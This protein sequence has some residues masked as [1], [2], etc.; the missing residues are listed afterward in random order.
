MSGLSKEHNVLR[1]TSLNERKVFTVLEPFNDSC[2]K[3]VLEY[4]VAL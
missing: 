2:D 4:S 3:K 1:V